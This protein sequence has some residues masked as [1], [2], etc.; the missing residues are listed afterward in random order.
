MSLYHLISNFPSSI[1][2]PP[3]TF[4]A[5]AQFSRAFLSDWGGGSSLSSSN[6]THLC[7]LVS[8]LSCVNSAANLAAAVMA[9]S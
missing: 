8:V 9:P 3:C 1:P 2:P 7:S 5:L 4:Q 6:P